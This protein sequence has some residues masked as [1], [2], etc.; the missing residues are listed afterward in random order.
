MTECKFYIPVTTMAPPVATAPSVVEDSPIH[1]L[2]KNG[3]I[4]DKTFDINEDYQ[5]NYRFAPI[6]EAEVSRAMIKR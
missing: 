6:E 3:P 5:G 1:L 4:I 2:K